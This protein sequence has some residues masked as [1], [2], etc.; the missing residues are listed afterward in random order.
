MEI[1]DDPE[2]QRHLKNTQIV[3]QV[4]YHGDIDRKEHMEKIRP[5]MEET[6][7]HRGG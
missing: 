1:P 5:P 7:A 6:I 2:V 4:A 3:S